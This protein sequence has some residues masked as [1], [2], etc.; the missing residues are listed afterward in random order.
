SNLKNFMMTFI[1]SKRS[2]NTAKSCKIAY[3]SIKNQSYHNI[4]NLIH[5]KNSSIVFIYSNMNFQHELYSSTNI[6]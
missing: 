4:S 1:R 5:N 6:L 2:L 3:N